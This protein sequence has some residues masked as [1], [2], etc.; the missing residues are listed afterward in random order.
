[1]LLETR[2]VHVNGVYFYLTVTS[3]IPNFTKS[4]LFSV[5]Y[6]RW[7]P[8]KPYIVTKIELHSAIISLNCSR[9]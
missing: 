4:C 3:K 8:Y 7:M 2:Q 6:L 5:N 1:M 9:I